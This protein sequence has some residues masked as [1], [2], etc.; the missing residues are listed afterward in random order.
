MEILKNYE[1]KVLDLLVSGVFSSDE[2]NRIIRESKLVS[3]EYTGSGYFLEISHP[4]L[5]NKRIVCDKPIVIGKADGIT[6]G[7]IVFIENN[8]LTIECH[9]WV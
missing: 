2:L 1:Q 5:P 4:S 3:Y 7:F 8:Q 9:S 6:C